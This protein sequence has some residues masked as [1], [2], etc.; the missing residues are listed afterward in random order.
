MGSGG[1]TRK[2]PEDDQRERIDA[3][4]QR[5]IQYTHYELLTPTYI[6]KK[7]E[8]R[9]QIKLNKE[10]QAAIRAHVEKALNSHFR[11]CYKVG[12]ILGKG[13]YS[14]VHSC[15]HIETKE[16]YAVKVVDKNKLSKNA[17]KSL[18]EEIRI[19]QLLKHP[20]LI[21]LKEVFNHGAMMYLVMERVEGGELFDE[22]VRLQ[23]YTEDVAAEI[24]FNFLD[25]LRYMHDQG[26]AH[27]DIK[28]ENILLLRKPQHPND[29][30]KDLKIADFG[31]S[32]YVGDGEPLNTCC[33][34]PRYIAPE[35]LNVGLFQKG[36][37][38]GKSCD[39]WAAG[40]IAYILLFGKA[41][42]YHKD[43]N[44]LWS[45]IVNGV[46][47]FPP[48][49]STVS[50]AAKDFVRKLICVDTK[51]RLTATQA[52]EHPFIAQRGGKVEHLA[53]TVSFLIEFNAKQK[54][55]GATFG[56]QSLSRVAYMQKCMDLGVKANTGLVKKME[57]GDLGD[58]TEHLDLT[59][60]YLGVKGLCAV[61]EMVTEGCPNLKSIDL[62]GN[63]VNNSVIEALVEMAL[64]HPRLSQVDLSNNP[65]SY[66]AGMALL[67][68]AKRNRNIKEL[69][70]NNT[71]IQ[72]GILRQI[73]VQLEQNRTGK[74]RDLYQH[75][76]T[77]A[78][79]SEA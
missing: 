79:P 51:L 38:Y 11:S 31:F 74:L 62:R 41:P 71:K 32:A 23:R 13:G 45:H 25:G 5:I 4:L 66:K 37:G 69:H 56:L 15:T 68:L 36:T 67:G 34:T 29:I 48:E 30:C 59:A 6:A 54:F 21:V 46:W 70:L 61:F 3:E 12:E 39:M 55:R 78:T 60:N 49:A 65:L 77:A 22:I 14:V 20:R 75:S 28:P 40:V 18:T 64:I 24:M 19:M 63:N 8:E 1:S 72:E 42:F 52:L 10:Q 73:N 2:G 58:D 35:V 27:R 43:R 57:L 26:Y 76:P 47:G 17:L 44:A 33:G 53:N 50:E 16:N 7:L 9:F